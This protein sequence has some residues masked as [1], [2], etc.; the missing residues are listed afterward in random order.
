MT[1]TSLR[2]V[3]IVEG[4]GE[5]QALPVLLRRLATEIAPD[6]WVDVPRPWRVSRDSL[7]AESGI[8]SELDRAVAGLDDVTGVL[9]LLDADDDCPAQLGPRL[10][11]RAR[12]ARPDLRIVV[13]LANREFE[14]WFLASASSLRG[15]AGLAADLQEPADPEQPRGCKEWLSK[16]R[17]DGRP[18]SP[19]KHQTSL[20][21]Q[22]DLHLARVNAPSFDKLWRDLEFLIQGY[23]GTDGG[24]RGEPT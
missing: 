1:D 20:A 24:G 6:L 21:A 23:A 11:A 17:M 14:A 19:K 2:I 3:T 7:V 8:E 16:R 18:Y 22:F 5:V 13:V 4:E 15:C 10:L 12:G 9:V